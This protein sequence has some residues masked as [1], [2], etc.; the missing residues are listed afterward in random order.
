MSIRI[1]LDQKESQVLFKPGGKLKIITKKQIIY[2]FLFNWSP[3]DTDFLLLNDNTIQKIDYF[4]CQEIWYTK[5][6]ST[7]FKKVLK[8]LQNGKKLKKELTAE[9]ANQLTHLISQIESLT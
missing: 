9:H 7:K 1:H 4:Q 3:G 2:G 6:I 5:P 8:E